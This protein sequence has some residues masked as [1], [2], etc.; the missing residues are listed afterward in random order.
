MIPM[1]KGA[2]ATEK[3]PRRQMRSFTIR[4]FMTGLML[5]LGIGEIRF[6]HFH[7][8]WE[9]MPSN[10]WWGVGW[11][12]LAAVCGAVAARDYWRKIT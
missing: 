1:P 10:R 2:T 5:G 9:E 3:E 6:Q 4:V 8:V 7:I 12:V 11:C